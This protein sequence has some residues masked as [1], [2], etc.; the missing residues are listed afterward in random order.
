MRKSDVQLLGLPLASQL[1][2]AIA[3]GKSR[4]GQIL[5]F[6]F[7]ILCLSSASLSYRYSLS[8]IIILVLSLLIPSDRKS[9]V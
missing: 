6:Q 3:T 5:T 4:L 2:L 9:V 1:P 7:L 8:L